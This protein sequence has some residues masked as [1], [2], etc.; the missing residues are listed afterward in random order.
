MPLGFEKGLRDHMWNLMADYFRGAMMTIARQALCKTV[1]GDELKS[2]DVQTGKPS[3]ETLVS[4]CE[5]QTLS[6]SLS[7][8]GSDMYAHIHTH[9]QT[10]TH[11][12]TSRHWQ[13]DMLMLIGFFFYVYFYEREVRGKL[14]VWLFSGKDIWGLLFYKVSQYT[15]L[16][17]LARDKKFFSHSTKHNSKA[18]QFLWPTIT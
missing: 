7:F 15:C 16:Y 14:K 10:Y 1:G 13:K 18:P 11:T 4:S 17:C 12:E 9:N 8:S 5:W 3:R 2:R 6:L